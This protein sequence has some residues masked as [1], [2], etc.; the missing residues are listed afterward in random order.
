MKVQ[1]TKLLAG[2][3]P[4]GWD[5]VVAGR[6]LG[7]LWSGQILRTLAWSSQTPSI[8]VLVADGAHQ[9]LFHFRLLGPGNPTRFAG[10]MPPVA[11]ADC[12]LHPGG[13]LP[14]R[15]FIGDST[16]SWRAQA[17]RAASDAVEAVVGDRRV[18][19]AFR[20]IPLDDLDAFAS[21]GSVSW[22]ATPELVIHNRWA[23]V[24]DYLLAVGRRQR[25]EVRRIT[26]RLEEIPDLTVQLETHL[27]AADASRLL[28]AVHRRR[29]PRLWVFPPVPVQYFEQLA[30]HPDVSFITYRRGGR[31]V[32]FTMLHDDG[33]NLV[34]SVFGQADA[35]DG[36]RAGFYLDMFHRAALHLVRTGRRRLFLGKGMQ[37]L[38]QRYGAEPQPQFL[39][40]GPPF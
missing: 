11:L 29:R 14:G 10:R 23:D 18:L 7:S 22:T 28:A 12:R 3:L 30:E 27:P 35:D 15:L 5:D 31:L 25:S 4:D 39:V 8:A 40:I 26:R 34:M 13:S 9:A 20:N 6:R 19:M 16:D 24:D 2:D 21:A 17:V 38:K 37:Q 36:G 1:A 33:T 32:A